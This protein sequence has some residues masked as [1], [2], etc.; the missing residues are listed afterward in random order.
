MEFALHSKVAIS[1]PKLKNL[2]RLTL[3]DLFELASRTVI[4]EH[5][6]KINHIKSTV[7]MGIGSKLYLD[8]WARD[9]L[10]SLIMRGK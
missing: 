3:D 9:T 1:G 2:D 6:E 5:Q 7:A 8:R 10:L 4:D